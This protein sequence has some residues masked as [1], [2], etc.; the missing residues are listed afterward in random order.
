MRCLAGTAILK[1]RS[2]FAR[3]H[4]FTLP[5][6]RMRDALDGKSQTVKEHRFGL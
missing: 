6:G 3:C 2:L 4:L 5:C 1:L